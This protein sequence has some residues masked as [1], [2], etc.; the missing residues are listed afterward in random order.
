M[1]TYRRSVFIGILAVLLS[2]PFFAAGN[3]RADDPYE[4]NDDWGTAY[5]PGYNWARTWLSDINGLG[6]QA[7][8]D[9]YLIDVDV[10][11]QRIQVDCRFTHADGDIHITL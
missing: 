11:S 5:H 9:W 3:A 4:E 10:A 6:I 1:H 2:I 8:E 7:D